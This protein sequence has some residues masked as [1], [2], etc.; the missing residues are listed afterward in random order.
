M[1]RRIVVLLVAAAVA[2]AAAAIIATA[3][4]EKGHPD[5]RARLQHLIERDVPRLARAGIYVQ[6]TGIAASCVSV[7]LA[8]PTEPN[9][10]YLRRR[11][12][13]PMCIERQSVAPARCAGAILKP[14]GETREVPNLLD[15]GVYEAG[16][17]AV[18]A[19]FAYTSSCPGQGANK[20]KRPSRLTPL[21]LARITA[22]CPA[23]GTQAPVNVPI[24]LQAEAVLPGGFTYTTT[25][26]HESYRAPRCVDGWPQ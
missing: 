26:F 6:G 20:A 23:A 1:N 25:A 18:A 8:N 14:G 24:A 13:K 9:V 17:R 21:A 5:R 16:R 10:I 15:L 4:G 19:G 12:G 3:S 2:V 11:F 7:R 22:Q